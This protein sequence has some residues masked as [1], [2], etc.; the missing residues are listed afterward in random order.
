MRRLAALMVVLGMAAAARADAP[1]LTVHGVLK[2]GDG[3]DR[4]Q[5]ASHAKVH[6]IQLREGQAYL[7]EL[8]SADF[9]SILRVEDGDGRILGQRDHRAKQGERRVAFVAPTAGKF[10]LVVTTV[11]PGRTGHFFLQA[12]ELRRAG[13][14]VAV[15]GKLD[16]DAQVVLQGRRLRQHTAQVEADRWYV[17]ELHSKDFDPYLI[18][19][20]AKGQVQAEDN[21]GG[22][23]TDARLVWHSGAGGQWQIGVLTA[24]PG[25]SGVYRVALQPYKGELP[26]ALTEREK[27]SRHG[28]E[29]NARGVKAT[30]AGE[31]AG[32]LELFQTALEVR[33]KLYPAGEFP[34]GHRDLSQALEN[35]GA[36]LRNAGQLQAALP[37]VEKAL[38]MRE[39]L[40]PV[41]H[42]PD[43]H[44][45]LANSV[46]NLAMVLREL[47]ENAAALP[48]AERALAIDEKLYPK[49]RHPD[50]SRELGQALNNLG[51][52]LRDLGEPARGLK[53][54]ERAVA[55]F[56]KLYPAAKYPS[57]TR[58]LAI[59]LHNVALHLRE[60]DDYAGARPHAERSMAMFA[61]LY[62]SA[63][64]PLG[65]P[66]LGV[67]WQSFGSVLSGA[68]EY[69]RAREWLDKALK[70][71]EAL[72]P[73]E[74][75]P[76][77]HPELAATLNALGELFRETGNFEQALLNTKRALAMRQRLYPA[78]QH[79]HGHFDVATSLTNYGMLLRELGELA[80]A[81][82]YLEQALGTCEKCFPPGY[83]SLGQGAI[84]LARNNL[85]LLLFDLGETEQALTFTD[86]A[87]AGYE[88]LFPADAYPD[89]H[90]ALATALSNRA[91][92]LQVLQRWDGATA[93]HRRVVAMQEKLLAR[94]ASAR[95]KADLA[96]SLNNLGVLLEQ[97]GELAEA[98]ACEER[99][100]EIRRQHYPA[101]RFPHGH[102]EL[103]S[104]LSNLGVLH[105]RASQPGKALPYLTEA[106][107]SQRAYCEQF[108]AG[109]PEAQALRFAVRQPPTLAEYLSAAAPP[110]VTP[111]KI[112]EQAWRARGILTRV[113]QRRHQAMRVAVEGDAEVRRQ[114]HVLVET[115]AQLSRLLLDPGRDPAARDREVARLTERKEQFERD[116]LPRLSDRKRDRDTDQ[117]RP[118]ELAAHLPQGA[119]F[120]DLV[121]Y[122]HFA[123]DRTEMPRYLAFVVRPDST[124][125]RFE[126]GVAEP[127]DAAVR[128][129]RDRIAKDA[130][131]PADAAKVAALIWRPIAAA[132]P[133]GTRTVYLAPDGELARLPWAALPGAKPGTVL[134]EELA[135]AVVPNGPYL[136][137]QLRFPSRFPAGTE[138]VLA[139]GD[140]DY[141]AGK[142]KYAALPGTGVEVR[143]LVELAS[144]REPL[145]LTGTAATWAR[146]KEHLPRVRYAHLATHGFF[147]DA[148]LA[149]ENDRFRAQ[150]RAWA[151]RPG[152]ADFAGMGLRS[153][154]AYSSLV[155]AGDEPLVSGEALVELPL[156]GLR[157]CVLSACETGLGVSSRLTGEGVEGLPRALHLAGCPNVVA[158]LWNVNDK[159]SAGL[160]AKFYHGLWQEGKTPLE[161]LRQAQL[162]V[163]L[164]PERI[165]D[166]IDRSRPS[167]AKAIELPP[168][169]QSGA[170]KTRRAPT[171][172]W[173]GVVLSGVGR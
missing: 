134:L 1:P 39:Q 10:R 46:N 115:R 124:I 147:D 32:A 7:V 144:P 173:A 3:L 95:G 38:A 44:A 93:V 37:Y 63:Q 143:R 107:A 5:K 77:G 45:D 82:A 120:V 85:G 140:V 66:D 146:L 156:E 50:G 97:R 163:L 79:P 129:W 36:G 88:K 112:Y 52:L 165:E 29:L 154:L 51:M 121:R 65:H 26:A 141:G 86:K 25:A 53:H 172:L 2:P 110:T 92:L 43:G 35:V 119:V 69:E 23:G 15:E 161:A 57:G 162:T 49:A 18:L 149:A 59:S 100:L 117:Q 90:W 127:I 74:R 169:A 27:L 54:C 125:V 135:V 61:K 9:D 105:C 19:A 81:R 8:R 106:L 108:A 78:E 166:L 155:L 24:A 164:H 151:A 126:L 114:W 138:S 87:V 42:F 128:A 145:T 157:L 48:Y 64:F 41:K 94:E 71:Q 33:S 70:L 12:V 62:P 160:M 75:F 13:K 133:M 148:A 101:S 40:Y 150:L 111:A 68:G 56:E 6:D 158:S 17:L 103:V 91:A 31:A 14:A 4:V 89:G 99:A 80:K 167:A 72:Y 58:D 20:S 132:L 84:A 131:T 60:L 122:S 16:Q 170:A 113:L 102:P 136:L 130:D 142:G 168:E 11:E 73:A 153:P 83:G 76:N 96:T 22:E 55:M 171:R 139:V 116:L 98:Q 159:A 123:P 30:E 137:E 47:G 21:H 28:A 67:S 118:A 152:S 34:G 109:A 104:A